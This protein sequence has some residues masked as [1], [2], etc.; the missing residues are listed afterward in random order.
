MYGNLSWNE[1]GEVEM[2]VVRRSTIMMCLINY[3][4]SSDELH[5]RRSREQDCTEN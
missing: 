3:F 5:V 1:G 2:L 4:G